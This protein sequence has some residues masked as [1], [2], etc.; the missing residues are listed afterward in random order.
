M[1]VFHSVEALHPRFDL[2]EFE[3]VCPTEGIRRRGV[4]DLRNQSRTRKLPSPKENLVEHRR[5][6]LSS[7]GVL[8]ADMIAPEECRKGWSRLELGAVAEARLG[9]R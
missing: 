8:L 1:L 4:W 3:T 6:Q 2:N 5:G 9:S 7:L